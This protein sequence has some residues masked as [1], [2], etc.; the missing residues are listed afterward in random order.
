[1]TNSMI[2][3]LESLQLMEDGILAGTGQLI[4][5]ELPNG[6]KK[7]VDTPEPIHTFQ[8]WK[9]LGYSVKKGQHAIAQF[10]IWKYTTGKKAEMSEEE[11]Q[12]KGYC[13]MK[14]A[15]FFKADQV[16]RKEN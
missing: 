10:P 8:A 9:N 13:F 11:A 7:Q 3:L 12:I 5:I 14:V 16:E 15:S 6:E 4:E 1:M 2:I